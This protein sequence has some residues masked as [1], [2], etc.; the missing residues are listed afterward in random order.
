[1]SAKKYI[2]IIGLIFG[3]V[4][5]PLAPYAEEFEESGENGA[6]VPAI[7]VEGN[8][9]CL[10]GEAMLD[11]DDPELGAPID[12]GDLLRCVPGVSGSRMGGHGVDPV[13]RGQSGSRVNVILDGALLYG[14]CPNRMDPPG[15]YAPYQS[16]DRIQVLKGPRSLIYSGGSGGAIIFDRNS[17]PLSGDEK[18]RA[19]LSTLYADNGE[20]K[21]ASADA[22]GGVSSAYVRAI[23]DYLE[24]GDYKDGEG[25]EVPSSF[26]SSHAAFMG[27]WT[28][29]SGF[30]VH[31]G[32]ETMNVDDVL[33]PGAG[34]DAPVSDA[35]IYRAKIE[36]RDPSAPSSGV[37]AEFFQSQVDHV[38]D[39]YSLR[40]RTAPSP[41]LA[42]TS[43]D[44][45]GGRVVVDLARRSTLFTVGAD[46]QQSEK[47]ALRYVGP[48]EDHV[49][50]VQSV[51]WPDATISQYGAFGI[52]EVGHGQDLSLS[53]GARYDRVEASAGDAD[54]DPPGGPMSPED[55]YA[56]YYGT[57]AND[58][59]ED[60]VGALVRLAARPG[61]DGPL[62]SVDLSRTVRSADATERFMA[63]NGMTPSARW[64][65]NPGIEPEVHYQAE[66][67]F[68]EEEEDWSLAAA[69]Y[70]D[71]A[72][73]YIIRDRARGQEGIMRIDGANI[74]RNV[75]AVLWGGEVEAGWDWT[76]SLSSRVALAYVYGNDET[77]DRPLPQIPPL[78]VDALVD[79]KRDKWRAGA[80]LRHAATQTRVD[81]DP[82][83]GS[84]LDAG[85]T[86][87][88]SVIDLYAAAFPT[89]NLELQ[90][91]IENLFDKTYADHL[92]K[93][94]AF[95]PEQIQV[96]EPGRTVWIKLVAGH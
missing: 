17:R 47:N 74:Y 27:G 11:P 22:A 45:H 64:V 54:L 30:G 20:R 35:D 82:A 53:V 94:N 63:S 68:L 50:I 44:A 25:E 21:G 79:Y 31:V 43:S 15:A 10:P 46:F 65:G 39:N 8:R 83:S 75:D 76:P 7:V 96:N 12:S 87:A 81:D 77:D 88:H 89:K 6:E 70:Y 29:E 57:G 67:G 95:D 23:Y 93:P 28:P 84:G 66:I 49:D 18:W 19:R 69:A 26:V 34:M 37:K 42:V 73:N 78:T 85:R 90:V 33:Y 5:F 14:G 61:E 38:M 51:L 59:E 2:Q 55:L 60:N 58:A 80:R 48:D 72:E 13:I 3:S 16:Y 24:A 36:W 62:L 71:W 32:W 86:P 56:L 92:N 1:M 52:L 9:I 41:L 40:E 4:F 91:G